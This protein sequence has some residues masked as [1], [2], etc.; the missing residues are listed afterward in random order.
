MS[1]EFKRQLT[2]QANEDFDRCHDFTNDLK[3][4]NRSIICNKI[5]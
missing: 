5:K 1:Y 4:I 3:S 2:E